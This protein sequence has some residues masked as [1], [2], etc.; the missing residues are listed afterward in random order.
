[1]ETHFLATTEGSSLGSFP[2]WLLKFLT[3]RCLAPRPFRLCEDGEARVFLYF[4]DLCVFLAAGTKKTRKN[5]KKMRFSGA[6]MAF[7]G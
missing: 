7:F 1:M 3:L 4:N 2:A 6:K 5:P